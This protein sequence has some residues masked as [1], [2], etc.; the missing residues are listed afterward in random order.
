MNL[1]QVL[2]ARQAPCSL[3]CLSSSRTH[4]STREVPAPQRAPV[5]RTYSQG[6]KPEKMMVAFA[7]GGGLGPTWHLTTALSE[8]LLH[9]L[10]RPARGAQASVSVP[11][12]RC[13]SARLATRS[14]QQ[15]E[16]SGKDRLRH[17]HC[18]VPPAQALCLGGLCPHSRPPPTPEHILSGSGGCSLT[19]L[20]VSWGPRSGCRAVAATA[21]PPSISPGG[22][23]APPQAA[24]RE[25]GAV[26]GPA[27]PGETCSC[28]M[29][30]VCWVQGLWGPSGER[31]GLASDRKWGS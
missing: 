18:P 1:A 3:G 26:I 6:R 14:G 28:L 16:V 31:G 8:L 19:G 4:F 20:G 7:S 23:W 17:C 30:I 9:A 11:G 25:A 10:H 29:E 2:R 22:S 21:L 13:P 12:V 27:L 24:V 15:E 5:P